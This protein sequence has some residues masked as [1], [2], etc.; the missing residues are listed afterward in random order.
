MKVNQV[1]LII[2]EMLMVWNVLIYLVSAIFLGFFAS[3]SIRFISHFLYSIM[4]CM[5]I[6]YYLF[7]FYFIFVE[8]NI[9]KIVYKFSTNSNIFSNKHVV[10]LYCILFFGMKCDLTCDRNSPLNRFSC[11]FRWMFPCNPVSTVFL[12]EV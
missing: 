9:S 4:Y 11:V 12:M 2:S 1:D 7:F 6:L 3:T 8:K 10:L 5:T